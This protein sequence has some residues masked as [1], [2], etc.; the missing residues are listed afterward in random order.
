MIPD[1][2]PTV[3]RV[4]GLCF[5]YSQN[6]LFSDLSAVIPP[7]VT[8][9]QGDE[10]AGKTSLMRLMAGEMEALSGNFQINGISLSDRPQ[11]YRSQVFLA[12]PRSEEFD[13][14]TPMDY[15]DT[16]QSRY[17]SFDSPLLADLTEAFSLKEHQSKFLYMLSTGTKRKV[18]LAAAF[19]CGATVTMLDEPFAA[20][21][22]L[23]SKWVLELLQEAAAHRTRA[24]VVA[25]YTAP[26]G[27]PLASIIKLPDGAGLAG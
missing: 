24:W 18:W 16:V 14:I 9:L 23:S 6:A 4:D 22:K 11:T 21:D 5:Q 15:W 13:S 1:L 25:D 8:L 3:L 12:D 10:G 2:S 7:G 19:A 20:L 26:F 17:P 27:V